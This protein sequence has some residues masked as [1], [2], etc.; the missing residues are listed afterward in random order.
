M[1]SPGTNISVR[2]LGDVVNATVVAEPLF[3]PKN[4]KLR[5]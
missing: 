1:A 2:V 4:E 5:C 3:D